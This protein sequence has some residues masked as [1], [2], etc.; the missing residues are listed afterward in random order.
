MGP[1]EKRDRSSGTARDQAMLSP[2]RFRNS[3]N[4][5]AN[6]VQQ[7]RDATHPK[8]WF[9]VNG[10]ENPSDLASRGMRPSQ[11]TSD[12]MWMS[13]PS[14][15]WQKEIVYSNEIGFEQKE[16]TKRAVANC[17]VYIGILRKTQPIPNVNVDLLKRAE[18]LI[19]RN[20]QREHFSAEIAS[21]SKVGR[22]DNMTEPFPRSRYVRKT[23]SLYRLDPFWTKTGFFE[24]VVVFGV[25]L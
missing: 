3:E 16:R 8:S 2:K 14:F 6:R 13:G 15:L 23:S 20:L 9:Y 22:K 24:L 4:N 21:I 1:M 11:L 17:M 18:N 5:R 10:R 19:I 7:I 12:S 25:R